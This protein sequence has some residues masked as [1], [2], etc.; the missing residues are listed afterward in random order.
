MTET[1]YNSSIF[2]QLHR[3]SIKDKRNRNQISP[4]IFSESHFVRSLFP[5]RG[6]L[7]LRRSVKRITNKLSNHVH[8]LVAGL[9]AQM[10]MSQDDSEWSQRGESGSPYKISRGVRKKSPGDAKYE[11]N[12][13]GKT[14]KATTS[15]S[16]HKRLECGVVPCEVC[17]ICG[18]RFKHRFVLNAHM[19]GCERRMNQTIQKKDYD[20]RLCQSATKK[21]ESDQIISK[22]HDLQIV[23]NDSWNRLKYF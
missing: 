18:R 13:C 15:L 21:N 5:V 11:C 19:V 16:R 6:A 20:Q 2:N 8:P 7:R 17:P 23:Q 22:D 12:R 3:K 1:T 9:L 10:L 4:S 14:Y